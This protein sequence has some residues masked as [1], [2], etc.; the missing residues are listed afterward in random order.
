M[1]KVITKNNQSMSWVMKSSLVLLLTA[2]TTL[3]MYQ[4]WYAP[5]QSQAAV[6]AGTWSSL[7]TTTTNATNG[8]WTAPTQYTAAGTAGSNRLL[9]VAVA[10]EVANVAAPYGMTILSAT[11]GG[12]ALT[13]MA[14]TRADTAS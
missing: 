13:E 9:L 14:T 6:A 4:G 7:G 1:G 12:V 10:A 8:T 3:F 5:K 11:Y 2:A